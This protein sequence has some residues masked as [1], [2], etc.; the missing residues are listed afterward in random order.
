VS[1]GA[2]YPLAC[3]NDTVKKCGGAEY[4]G[5]DLPDDQAVTITPVHVFLLAR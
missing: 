2:R 5:F 3:L 1:V 4:A